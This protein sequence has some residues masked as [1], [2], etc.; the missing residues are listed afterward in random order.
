MQRITSTSTYRVVHFV[1]DNGYIQTLWITANGQTEEYH[2]HHGQGEDEEHDAHVAP[3]AQHVL[4]EQS[5]YFA[6]GRNLAE[7]GKAILATLLIVGIILALR[8]R[9]T[10][11]FLVELQEKKLIG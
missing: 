5:T 4:G 3:H 9:R 7:I 11:G 10:V 2:L 8:W 1:V 6:L